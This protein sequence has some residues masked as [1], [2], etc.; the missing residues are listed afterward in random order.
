MLT[1]VLR[2]LAILSRLI[3]LEDLKNLP[4]RPEEDPFTDFSIAVSSEEMTELYESSM[5]RRIFLRM[6][7]SL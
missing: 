6:S 4:K 2:Y 1:T 7:R 5:E 3:G